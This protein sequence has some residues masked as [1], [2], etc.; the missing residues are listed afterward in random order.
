MSIRFLCRR[1]GLSRT[2]L[3]LVLYGLLKRRVIKTTERAPWSFDAIFKI[4]DVADPYRFESESSPA[5]GPGSVGRLPLPH[6]CHHSRI[7]AAAG[8]C[9]GACTHVSH[10]RAS[11]RPR[12]RF[13]ALTCP[14]RVALCVCVRVCV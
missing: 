2:A 3:D 12:Q 4:T 7:I 1:F 9:V 11:H 14:H 13:P 5:D 6:Q 10:G 8:S